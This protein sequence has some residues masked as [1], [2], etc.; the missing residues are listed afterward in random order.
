MHFPHTHTTL[1]DTKASQEPSGFALLVCTGRTCRHICFAVYRFD[2]HRSISD[3]HRRSST[4]SIS[5]SVPVALVCDTA[6]ILV[7]LSRQRLALR[8]TDALPLDPRPPVLILSAGFWVVFF[9]FLPSGE[10]TRA[11]DRPSSSFYRSRYQE[12][13]FHLPTRLAAER[14]RPYVTRGTFDST[15][16]DG[17]HCSCGPSMTRARAARVRVYS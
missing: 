15:D 13:M 2:E 4:T 8:A 10:K 5:L 14:G 9:F 3:G 12:A 11:R 6:G 1:V 17:D 16:V 7:E